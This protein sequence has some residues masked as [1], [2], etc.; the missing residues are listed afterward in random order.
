MPLTGSHGPAA[1]GNRKRA[2]EPYPPVFPSAAR[3]RGYGAVAARRMHAAWY[4]QTRPPD[5]HTT[6]RTRPAYARHLAVG[7]TE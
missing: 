4:P 2:S 3:S 1:N 6:G 7:G 5:I